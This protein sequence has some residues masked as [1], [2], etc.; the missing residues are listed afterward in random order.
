M[1]IFALE[2]AK[3]SKILLYTNS[4]TDRSLHNREARQSESD[5]GLA[6][7]TQKEEGVSLELHEAPR[8]TRRGNMGRSVF[9]HVNS[10][11]RFLKILK[12]APCVLVISWPSTPDNKDA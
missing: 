8:L 6:Y 7:C 10:A 4:S 9:L 11:E 5:L 12:V 3:I 1:Q 2:I